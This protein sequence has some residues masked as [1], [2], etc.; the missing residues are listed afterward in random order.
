MQANER[1]KIYSFYALTLTVFVLLFLGWP[2][3]SSYSYLSA[4]AP[5]INMTLNTPDSLARRSC[6]LVQNSGAASLRTQA[7]QDV[8]QGNPTEIRPKANSVVAELPAA[9]RKQMAARL[10]VKLLFSGAI[11]SR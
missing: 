10:A 6:G 1:K 11:F 3:F 5:A 8:I 7:K 4:S 9:R 2:S